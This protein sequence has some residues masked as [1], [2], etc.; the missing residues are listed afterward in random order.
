MSPMNLKVLFIQRPN[1]YPGENAPEVLECVTEFDYEDNPEY[2]DNRVA[3]AIKEKEAGEYAN[4]RVID[5]EVDQDKISSILNES[6]LV[7]GKVQP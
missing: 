5:V 4:V 3:E 1:S 6:P 2:F 7:R